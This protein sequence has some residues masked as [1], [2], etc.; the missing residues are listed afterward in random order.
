M[1][2][3]MR[4]LP[5]LLVLALP[6]AAC[7]AARSILPRIDAVLADADGDADDADSSRLA[8]EAAMPPAVEQFMVEPDN[9]VAVGDSLTVTW[10]T[11]GGDVRL[12]LAQSQGGGTERCFEDLPPSGSLGVRIDEELTGPLTLRLTVA[13][14]EPDAASDE[15]DL[16]E[17][18][19]YHWF[20]T[21]ETDGCPGTPIYETNAAA[22]LF[23]H[24]WLLWIDEPGRYFALTDDIVE[25][26]VDGKRY[27]TTADPLMVIDD[28]EADVE[29]PDG[30]YAPVSG[31]G[32]I[33]RGDAQDTGYRELLGWATIPEFG[34]QARY[35]CDAQDEPTCYVL[36]PDDW[37]VVLTPDGY[38][39]PAESGR[40]TLPQPAS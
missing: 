7:S 21:P 24:G 27:E 38:W 30:L 15:I 22:Q 12:C 23:E 32:L 19:R 4:V 40:S 31:F 18:C 35:Q 29:P 20:T 26:E 6:V 17:I 34:Y 39:Y 3:V 33:W 5:V 10:E 11:V 14:G 1:K 36:H 13:K 8:T 16:G 9:P 25:P 28:T 2:R 37:V